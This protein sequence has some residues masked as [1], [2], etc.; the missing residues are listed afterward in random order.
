MSPAPKTAA[1]E[2]KAKK[3]RKRKADAGSPPP[4]DAAKVDKAADFACMTAFAAAAR[5]KDPT[6]EPA[7]IAEG[8]AL[9]SLALC[10]AAGTR[11]VS[12]DEIETAMEALHA[13]AV[14]SKP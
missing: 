14:A 2:P 11:G 1:A 4:S 6:T 9:A 3:P 12:V 10:L 13:K 7:A 5:L 8:V